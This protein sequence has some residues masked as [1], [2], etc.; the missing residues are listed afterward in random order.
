MSSALASSTT[1]GTEESPNKAKPTSLYAHL[2]TADATEPRRFF[3]EMDPEEVAKL[4]GDAAM[5]AI[6]MALECVVRCVRG[7]VGS[8]LTRPDPLRSRCRSF[9]LRTSTWS[10]PRSSR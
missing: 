2:T 4:E 5:G 1:A 3:D 6:D 8:R 9:P 7:V 10:S